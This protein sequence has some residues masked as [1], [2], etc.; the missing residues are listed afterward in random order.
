MRYLSSFLILLPLMAFSSGAAQPPV[1]PKF[2]SMGLSAQV[3]D[4]S[5]SKKAKNIVVAVIVTNDSDSPKQMYVS[6]QP[7]AADNFGNSFFA[8]PTASGEVGGIYI[9]SNRFQCLQEQKD[10]TEAN[11]TELD[12]GQS[13]T[14]TLSFPF[15]NL[16][17]TLGD[18]ISVGLLVHA[19]DT[20]VGTEAKWKTISL[21]AAKIALR[22]E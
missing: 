4:A 22:G 21:G 2:G 17:P 14:I 9:C 11:A 8:T 1:T 16:S 15:N 6:D 7:T 20:S 19:K 13:L 18:R 12:P 10:Q 5:A 3:V